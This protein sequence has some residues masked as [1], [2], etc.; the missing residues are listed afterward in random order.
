MLALVTQV[1]RREGTLFVC[2]D[3]AQCDI[4]KGDI[5]HVVWTTARQPS[6]HGRDGGA[7]SEGGHSSSAARL[8]CRV[9]NRHN[10]LILHPDVLVT[11][12]SIMSAVECD[13]RYVPHRF[14]P[15]TPHTLG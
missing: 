15:H 8:V 12:S 10:Y 9:D 3:W 6:H 1:S 11:P 7:V 5:V 14:P 2:E 4:R 13:R